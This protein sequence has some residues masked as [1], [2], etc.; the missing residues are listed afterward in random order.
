[1]KKRN[2]FMLTLLAGICLPAAAQQD[3]T[4]LT[5]D[6]FADQSIDVGAQKVFT[7]EQSTVAASV[8]TRETVDKRS[9]KNIGNSIIGQG[10]GLISLDGTGSYFVQNPTFYIRGLQSLSTSTPLILVDG[11]ERDI[12]V[13]T[14]EEVES[15][16]ILKDAAAALYGYKGAN[17]AVLVTTKRGKYNSNEMSVHYDHLINYQTNRPKFVNG[18]TYAAAYQR[19]FDQ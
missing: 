16:T 5:G 12:T 11:V 17:G 1:M 13:V 4:M 14:P 18:P 6:A 2:I 7:R 15:V 9:A 8:I 10:N 3:S 19:G